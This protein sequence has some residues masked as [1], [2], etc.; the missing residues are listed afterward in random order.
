MTDVDQLQ[1]LIRNFLRDPFG[2]TGEQA[3]GWIPAADI[4][5]T[6][7]AYILEL[8]VP[9]LKREDVNIE[10]RDSEVR[11]KGE[12]KEKERTGLLRRQT[13]RVGQF[14]FGMT[15]PGNINP[16]RA[17]H[18]RS[19]IARAYS[20]SRQRCL[21]E[22]ARCRVRFLSFCAPRLAVAKVRLSAWWV[23]LW[24]W[25]VPSINHTTVG[26]GGGRWPSFRRVALRSRSRLGRSR[27]G[28][29][30]YGSA[31]AHCWIHCGGSFRS[32]RP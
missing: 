1:D 32:G 7:D 5:E 12:I 18:R 11:I 17:C 22:G 6:D 14:E 24:G 26:R 4:E 29:A 9:G 8:D 23:A 28:G 27:P 13:R 15:L 31:P 30:M 16:D 10:L 2:A 25:V 21:R 3:P 20:T 19:E